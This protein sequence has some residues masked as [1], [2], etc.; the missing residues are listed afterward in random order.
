MPHNTRW[1]V[2]DERLLRLTSDLCTHINCTPIPAYT[3]PPLLQEGALGR[4]LR[5]EDL[6]IKAFSVQGKERWVQRPCVQGALRSVQNFRAPWSRGQ[7]WGILHG[8]SSRPHFSSLRPTSLK[9]RR[10]VN[11]FLA[12]VTNTLSEGGL[13]FT[14][15]HSSEVMAA[16]T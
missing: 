8:L 9:G 3:Y 16:D 1:A 10:Q 2:P 11:C 13:D 4:S 5:G 7:A 15:H 6:W 14:V 12:S